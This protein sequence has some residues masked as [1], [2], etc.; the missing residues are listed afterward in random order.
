MW[1]RVFGHFQPQDLPAALVH[2]V[3]ERAAA[4]TEVE[5]PAARRCWGMVWIPCPNGIG[6]MARLAPPAQAAP[7][8]P[9]LGP[10][11]LEVRG[12]VVRIELA[13][14]LFAGPRVGVAQA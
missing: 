9:G 11:A 14:D 8:R 1:F 7:P 4:A 3:Q 2:A 10:D 6:F 13:D 5:Q 12:V